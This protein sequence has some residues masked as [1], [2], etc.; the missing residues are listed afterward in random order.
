[1]AQA[2]AHVR[3]GALAFREG[4]QDRMLPVGGSAWERW[5]EQP[6]S[7]AFRFEHGATGFTARR[8]RQRGRWYWY[9]YRRRGGRL[10]KAY[11][12]RAGDLTLARL[13]EVG[14]RLDRDEAA[15]PST[16]PGAD[17]PG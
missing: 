8:E 17:G 1:M 14:A 15:G 9:A 6:G 13:A 3:D 16:A 7:T 12:G 10:R 5:L 11:L 2:G 4:E